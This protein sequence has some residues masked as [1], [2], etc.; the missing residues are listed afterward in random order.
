MDLFYEIDKDVNDVNDVKNVN[1][2]IT[3]QCN[4]LHSTF[5]HLKM[6]WST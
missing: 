4:V 3:L 5:C 2:D 1:V 6:I